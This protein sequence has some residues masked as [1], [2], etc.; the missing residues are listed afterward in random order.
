M[1]LNALLRISFNE[2]GN[3][4]LPE[5]KLQELIDHAVKNVVKFKEIFE[6]LIMDIQVNEMEI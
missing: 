1:F 4:E 3:I 5:E 2:E 6:P